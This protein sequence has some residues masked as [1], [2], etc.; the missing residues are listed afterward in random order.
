MEAAMQNAVEVP[1]GVARMVNS[2]WTTLKE[3]AVHGNINCKS[4]LQVGARSLE[5]GVW[6]AYYNVMINLPS[7]TDQE[8]KAK[9]SVVIPLK[10][11]QECPN[12]F[13]QYY[14]YLLHRCVLR[15]TRHNF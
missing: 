8:Y 4:D 13:Q 12:T 14:R 7:I 15:Y 3:L 2:C 10:S 1:M 6:G 9:V 11:V 5:L